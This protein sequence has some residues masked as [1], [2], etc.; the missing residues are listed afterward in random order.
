M[1]QAKD[2]GATADDAGAKKTISRRDFLKG[3]GAFVATAGVAGALNA[4]QPAEAPAGIVGPRLSTDRQYPAAPPPPA[5]P[6]PADRLRFFSLREARAVDAL[7]GRILPGTPDDP[8]AR[9]AGVLNYI[10]YW[11]A[12]DDGYNM[13]FYRKPP[14]AETFEGGGPPPPAETTP[15]RVIW[16][17]KDQIE[18]YGPQ[19]ALTPQDIYRVGLASLDRYAHELHGQDFADL[20][21]DQM[22]AVVD[23]LASGK[24]T[25]FGDPSAKGFFSQVRTDLVNGLFSDPAYGGNK[26]MAG[27]KLIGYPGAQRA[28]TPA[29]M[30]NGTRREPQSLAQLPHFHPGQA[31]GPDVILPVSGSERSGESGP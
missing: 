25:G 1:S 16:V 5:E 13:P 10:D 28:Y 14:F 22:D 2:P 18:R 12:Q 4:C 21:E 19:S 7:I 17:P 8:G 29:E 27:W 31:A 26:E 30:A 24:A 15:Y 23:D 3:V 20:S 11:L 6:P 9:E